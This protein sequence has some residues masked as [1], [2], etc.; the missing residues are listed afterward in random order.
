MSLSSRVRPA[1]RIGAPSIRGE[2]CLELQP[3]LDSTLPDVAA[4]LRRLRMDQ[5]LRASIGGQKA[6]SETAFSIERRLR[7]LLV[8]N[9]VARGRSPLGCCVV[10]RSGA[11]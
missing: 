7:W 1:L 2:E 6:V 5:F 11:I 4:F 8:E 9:P 3:I 10:D